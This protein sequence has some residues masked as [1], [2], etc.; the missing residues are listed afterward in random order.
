M[1]IM[2]V[3]RL[4]KTKPI[5]ESNLTQKD[6]VEV[7]IP[8]LRHA[9][10]KL[11]YFELCNFCSAGGQKEKKCSKNLPTNRIKEK[12]V[13]IS[14]SHFQ[15]FFRILIG[16]AAQ[17][18]NVRYVGN[19]IKI[20]KLPFFLKNWYNIDKILFRFYVNLAK[21]CTDITLEIHESC[22]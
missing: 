4:K 17:P 7:R 11:R 5:S 19:I 12:T 15:P 6:R 2:R 14:I 9:H 1:R 16:R 8:S 21:A 3:F 20:L 10:D 13:R 22:T 18:V